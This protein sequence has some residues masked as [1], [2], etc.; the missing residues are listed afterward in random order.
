MNPKLIR[1]LVA[2]MVFVV[3]LFVVAAGIWF[4]SPGGQGYLQSFST[5]P[6]VVRIA[7][8]SDG[9]LITSG[10]G[11]GLAAE[12]VAEGGLSRVVFIVDGQVVQENVPPQAGT[13]VDMPV[14]IWFGARAGWHT[15]AVVA[16]DM[17][18]RAS[19]E[20]NVRVGVVVD[21][22]SVG[23]EGEVMPGGGDQPD[24]QAGGGD[25]GGNLPGDANLP[26]VPPDPNQPPVDEPPPAGENLPELPPPP[27][28][29]PP[30]IVS[31]RMASS[32]DAN[33]VVSLSG[34][35]EGKD[36]LGLQRLVL[37]WQGVGV[38][39][40]EVSM[41]CGGAQVCQ[42]QHDAVLAP[43]EWIF[44][45]QAIDISGQVSLPAV[46]VV[47]VLPIEGQP[48]AV[49]DDA[50]DDGLLSD[51][52]ADH[53]NDINV[54]L[55]LGDLVA[56]GFDLGE[57]WPGLQ[58][59]GVDVQARGECLTYLLEPFVDG[60]RHTLTVDCDLQ[61]A[62]ADE[63]LIPLV[64][65]YLPNTNVTGIQLRI[66][67]WPLRKKINSCSLLILSLIGETCAGRDPR[68]VLSIDSAA[69]D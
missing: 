19:P 46:R 12:A 64:D 57:L 52:I 41:L 43:G 62:E 38:E 23:P 63:F 16:Y 1:L 42:I 29:N 61:T 49:A 48:P 56:P 59:D 39:P 6:P 35:S 54:N 65:K 58:E 17:A 18:G 37:N 7:S 55:D 53:W 11:I 2:I 14:F 30:E 26:A 45:V 22:G 69:E 32:V 10:Q 9:S 21:S 60:I 28:D 50:L 33:G 31:F 5:P 4:F 20:V 68:P 66:L 8:P 24:V 27:Q 3:C 44:S 47:Q 25:G 15:L 13:K 40:G 67:E 36:D 51:W 34:F